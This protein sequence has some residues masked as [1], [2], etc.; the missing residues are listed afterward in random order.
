MNLSLV[1]LIATL[2]VLMMR[3]DKGPSEEINIMIMKQKVYS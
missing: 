2:I 3:R 1:V